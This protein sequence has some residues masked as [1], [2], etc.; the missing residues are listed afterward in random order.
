MAVI[1]PFP[2]RSYW[3][4]AGLALLIAGFL[5]GPTAWGLNLMVNYSLVKPVCAAGSPWVLTAVSAAALGTTCAGAIVSWRCWLRL[6]DDGNTEG[7]RTVDRS[8]FIAVTGMV[9]NAFFI[10]L[11]TVSIVP[12]YVVSP[13]E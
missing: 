4:G 8:Y 9:L 6:R 12:H 13:C 11:I 2:A 3:D 10:L 1:E 5:A 7:A